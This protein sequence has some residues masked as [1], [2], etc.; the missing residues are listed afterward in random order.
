M[1]DSEQD[2]MQA[3]EMPGTLPAEE[4]HIYAPPA[5]AN[6]GIGNLIFTCIFIAVMILIGGSYYLW[7]HYTP[8]DKDWQSYAKNA[9]TPEEHQLISLLAVHPWPC[10]DQD[11]LDDALDD[12]DNVN[13]VENGHTPL[14]L[15][16]ENNDYA[17]VK[18]LLS[19]GA[20]PNLEGPNLPL[21]VALLHQFTDMVTLL[22]EAGADP[23]PNRLDT[24]LLFLC[25]KKDYTDGVK[26]LLKHGC[27]PNTQNVRDHS[28]PALFYVVAHGG[29]NRRLIC[30]ELVKAGANL[31]EVYVSYSEADRARTTDNIL[32]WAITQSDNHAFTLWLT[33]GLISKHK[34]L[35]NF[36]RPETGATPLLLAVMKNKSTLVS[37]LLENGASPNL[38]KHHKA[39]FSPLSAALK[40]KNIYLMQILLEAGADANEPIIMDEERFSPL[41]QLLMTEKWSYGQLAQA[42][43]LL[44]NHGA[45]PKLCPK[46]TYPIWTVLHQHEYLTE[47]EKLL[48]VNLLVKHGVSVNE[49]PAD[50]ASPLELALFNSAYPESNLAKALLEAGAN[51]DAGGSALEEPLLIHACIL[52]KTQAVKLLL[53][54]GADP[55]TKCSKDKYPALLYALKS[56]KETEAAATACANLLIKAGANTK[57][58]AVIDYAPNVTDYNLSRLLNAKPKNDMEKLVG[59]MDVSELPDNPFDNSVKDRFPPLLHPNLA[60]GSSSAGKKSVAAINKELLICDADEKTTLRELQHCIR[61]LYRL[62]INS[63]VNNKLIEQDQKKI[64]PL[65]RWAKACSE[66]DALG[67][68]HPALEAQ[69]KQ[70]VN[71]LKALIELRQNENIQSVKT[72]TERAYNLSDRMKESGRSR[73][74]ALLRKCADFFKDTII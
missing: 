59:H 46:N 39:V 72:A 28:I 7:Q 4:L 12:I 73:D 2:S 25:L 27:S 44:L 32:T 30:T 49:Y 58:P 17:T 29:K 48:C 67:Y 36:V 20:D 19:C 10:C 16:V 5:P 43:S 21:K 41:N 54:H 52:K 11:Q 3:P 6:E 33:N 69:A 14:T 31:N 61:E 70:Q 47:E 64:K 13:L 65:Q 55:N 74:A 62:K 56:T 26:A 37:L 66:P 18:K 23:N 34:K 42:L 60:F 63:A 53:E 71:D 68:T 57:D 15:A 22:L 45:E 38:A 8:E 50:E 35:V 9:E 1:Q 40:E 24:P 51:I